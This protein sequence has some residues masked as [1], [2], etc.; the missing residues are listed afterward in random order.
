MEIKAPSLKAAT[1]IISSI[2]IVTLAL[3]IFMIDVPIHVDI[4]IPVLY[5]AVVL[6][7]VRLYVPAV[8][9]SCRWDVSY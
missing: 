5:V 6:M 8:S 7:S 4:A 1:P 3:A 9:L 2:A